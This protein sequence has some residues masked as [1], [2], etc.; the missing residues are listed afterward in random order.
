MA[1]FINESPFNYTHPLERSDSSD[2]WLTENAYFTGLGEDAGESAV[3]ISPGA[4][5]PGAAAKPWYETLVNAIVP[6]AANIYA[7]K[8]LT[9]LNVARSQQGLA[10]ITAAEF[11]RTYQPAAAQVQVGP[12]AQAQKWLMYGAVGVGALVVLRALKII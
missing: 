3:M 7:Q 6:T 8:Q 5:A 11:Q 12:S 2:F 4:S 1:R 10:P 9:S